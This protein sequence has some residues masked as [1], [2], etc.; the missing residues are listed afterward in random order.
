MLNF[1]ERLMRFLQ[2]IAGKCAVPEPN[3]KLE[4]LLAD[5]AGRM[6]QVPL[7]SG[8]NED[9]G[10]ALVVGSDG[11]YCLSNGVTE[12]DAIFDS[13]VGIHSEDSL[14]EVRAFVDTPKAGPSTLS[15]QGSFSDFVRVR[16]V[17]D[18]QLGW[19][20]AN[21]RYVDACAAPAAT[22][23][24]EGKIPVVDDTGAYEL[25]SLIPIPT[26]ADE[27]KVPVAMDDGSYGLKTVGGGSGMYIIHA[28]YDSDS[29]TYQLQGN[30]STIMNGAYS[31]LNS[32]Q[33]PVVLVSSPYDD[34]GTTQF[35]V[36][37]FCDLSLT[38]HLSGI[39]FQSQK[40]V[41]Y[42]V[43]NTNPYLA[44]ESF[45]LDT[46]GIRKN[47]TAYFDGRTESQST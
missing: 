14:D 9:I 27:G 11:S 39:Y 36:L 15:L 7:I 10:K 43:P 35:R 34:Y 41:F 40:C 20:A 18:P 1:K 5:I 33:V 24:D 29:G 31:A 6:N 25:R 22:A 13:S 16:N 2:A 30:P 19:D 4:R 21:K 44:I 46:N 17:A 47:W 12:R 23:D 3:T 28:T 45:I 37:R 42:G 38:P 32:G 26:A 8:K